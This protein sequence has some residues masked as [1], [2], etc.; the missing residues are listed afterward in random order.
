MLNR[1]FYQLNLL[2]CLIGIC[3]GQ[4]TTSPYVLYYSKFNQKVNV[5]LLTKW[6]L[7]T[8]SKQ[9]K[10]PPKYFIEVITMDYE[11]FSSQT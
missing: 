10:R 8:T 11:G 2:V 6:S 1:F 7:M 3:S 9:R 4:Q 5:Q